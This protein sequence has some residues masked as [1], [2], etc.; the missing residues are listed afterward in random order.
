MSGEGAGSLPDFLGLGAQRAGTT[1]LDRALR[2]HPQIYLP[3]RRKEL[4]FFDQHHHLGPQWYASFFPP[5]AEARHY[6]R[7][8][9][10]TPRYLFD[11][12]VPARIHA[13]LP[14][15]RMVVLLRDP[16]RRAYSQYG[17]HVRDRGERRAFSDFIR[18]HKD[19]F[20]RGL[21]SEQL[22]RY[23]AL[24]DRRQ[25]LVLIY[26]ESVGQGAGGLMALADFLEVDAAPLAVAEDEAVNR[27]FAPRW[28]RLR[29]AARRFGA[30]LRSIGA[31]GV[32]NLAKGVGV[33]AL[34]GRR[35]MPALSAED[36]DWLTA[37]YAEEVRR[38]ED[39]LGRDLRLWRSAS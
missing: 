5:A 10:I 33:P 26:E 30:A 20:Q 23:F 39:L 34:F 8:G 7:L 11:P 22:E 27:S 18:D 17:L 3:Q 4:H 14:R 2:R 13:L 31:D 38:L 21:Y 12:V 19:V 1:W 24:F 32:V 28:P 29:A 15:C 37:R 9:E 25:I 6:R 36:A 35:P 16:V